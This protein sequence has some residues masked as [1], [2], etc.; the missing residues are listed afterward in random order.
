MHSLQLRLA[1]IVLPLLILAIGCL[2]YLAYGQMRDSRVEAARE[3]VDNALQQATGRIH[4]QL[5]TLRTHLEIFSHSEILEKYLTTTSEEERYTVLQPALIRLFSGYQVAVP[6][7][8]EVSLILPNGFEDTRV[9]NTELAN[10]T[11]EEGDTP[12]FQELKRPDRPYWYGFM[13][14]PDNGLWGIQAGKRLLFGHGSEVVEGYLTIRMRP[15]FLQT[16]VETHRVGESGGFL[17]ADGE[18]KILYA[19]RASLLNGTLP[20]VLQED[21]RE[22]HP[23]EVVLGNEPCLV[24]LDDSES[25]LRLVAVLPLKELK[26]ETDTL[27]YLTGGV[28]ILAS[29]VMGLAMILVLRRLVV[30]PLVQLK[31]AS[32]RIGEGDLSTP[33]GCASTDEIGE[34]A[35]ALERMRQGL[36]ASYQELALARDAAERASRAKS[37]FLANMSHEIRTPLNALLGM[38][39]LL[40]RMELPPKPLERVATIQCAAQS[41]AKLVDDLL[42]FSRL[43]TTGLERQPIAFSL[44]GLWQQIEQRYLKKARDKGLLLEYRPREHLPDRYFGERQRLDHILAILVDN[45]IKFSEKGRIVVEVSGSCAEE[46]CLLHFSVTDEGIGIVQDKISHVFEPFT[47]GDASASRRHGGTGLGLALCHRLVTFLGGEIGVESR[48]GEGSRFWFRVPMTLTREE[49]AAIA[50]QEMDGASSRPTQSPVEPVNGD[51]QALL[52]ELLLPL[53]NRE[54]KS[55]LTLLERMDKMVFPEAIAGEM[56]EMVKLIRRYR[57]KEAEQIIRGIVD[58]DAPSDSSEGVSP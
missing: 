27:F 40:A 14:N 51:Y 44:T 9:T 19:Y 50:A 52:R 34:V 56:R 42:D 58:A 11:E 46:R 7:Y 33:V 54:P 45:A 26:R 23:R 49:P 43:E 25:G 8:Y 5:Q 10:K 20:S 53:R 38:S 57:L 2:G 6:D 15:V 47:Q 1:L 55:C 3:E 24:S 36:S 4:N 37:D 16:L 35:G 18:G 41:L 31:Q 13:V 12:F 39:H 48:L 22:G 29:L 32:K 21:S 17:V 30:A 28:G